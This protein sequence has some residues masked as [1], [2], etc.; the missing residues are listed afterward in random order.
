MTTPLNWT[1]VKL[2]GMKPDHSQGYNTF[3]GHAIAIVIDGNPVIVLGKSIGDLASIMPVLKAEPLDTSLVYEAAL[4]SAKAV[5]TVDVPD[6]T[7]LG[8]GSVVEAVVKPVATTP[9]DEDDDL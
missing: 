4:V 7:V 2:I 6:V 8:D 9:V 1:P 5:V 3:V